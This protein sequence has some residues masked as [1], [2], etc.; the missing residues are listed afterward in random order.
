[1]LGGNGIAI[2][3]VWLYFDDMKA[4]RVKRVLQ[5]YDPPALDIHA[6]YA[7]GSLVPLRVR[8]FIEALERTFR[9]TPA[10]AELFLGKRAAAERR[11][12]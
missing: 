4:G 11:A 9:E 10:L 3:P 7:P 5:R 1:M 2:G 8:H 6:L 12:R